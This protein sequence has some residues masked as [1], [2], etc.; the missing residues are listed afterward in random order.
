MHYDPTP[1]FRQLE[2]G[3]S[4]WIKDAADFAKPKIAL[5]QVAD[6]TSDAAQVGILAVGWRQAMSNGRQAREHRVLADYLLTVSAKSSAVAHGVL[7]AMIVRKMPQIEALLPVSQDDPIWGALGAAPRPALLASCYVD[8]TPPEKP[9]TTIT[10]VRAT[11]APSAAISGQVVQQGKAVAAASVSIAGSDHAVQTDTDG[12]F[13]LY[14]WSGQ[15]LAI[16][17]R[18]SI[19]VFKPKPGSDDLVISIKKEH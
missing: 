8:L 13:T 11:F 3:F 16:A 14:G 2:T 12:R 10:E 4:D 6:T 9:A 15:A 5:D 1:A 19:Q 7:G 17:H 18:G